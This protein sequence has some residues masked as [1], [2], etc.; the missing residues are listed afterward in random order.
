MLSFAEIWHIIENK[1]I[2]AGIVVGDKKEQAAD[3]SLD[4][5]E[6]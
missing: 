4:R 6:M 5:T 1:K 2:K 3:K